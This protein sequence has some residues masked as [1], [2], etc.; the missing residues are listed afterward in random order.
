[1]Y[2]RQLAIVRQDR[3]Q[4]NEW[5][6]LWNLGQMHYQSGAV[7]TAIERATESLVILD[8]LEEPYAGQVREQIAKWNS[9]IDRD[10]T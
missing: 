10:L 4:Y 8:A 2:Q 3:D 7:T 6:A 5:I 9:D 1:M